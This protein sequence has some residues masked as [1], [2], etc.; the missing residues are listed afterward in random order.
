MKL[1][2]KTP[3]NPVLF[4]TGKG[5]GYILWIFLFTTLFGYVKPDN[6]YQVIWN[7]LSWLITIPAVFIVLMSL[8]NLGK[9]TSLG[10]PSED[11]VLKTGGLYNYSRNPMYLGFNLLTASAMIVINNI[12]ITILGIYVL[13]VY[14][15]II[16]AEERFL[17]ARFG[18]DYLEYKKSVRRYI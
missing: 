16:K 9:S 11:T 1:I 10:I 2:G 13:I 5:I 3:I 12:I 4:F 6:Q 15:L 18:H 17:A 8:F 7:I 14:H